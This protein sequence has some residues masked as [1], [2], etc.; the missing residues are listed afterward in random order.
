MEQSDKQLISAYLAGDDKSLAL[1][2]NRYIRLVYGYAYG[3]LHNVSD[4]EDVAQEV[5][6]KVWLNLKKFDQSKNF[7]TWLY[8]I[9]KNT[10]I[11]YLRKK[12]DLPFS[13]FTT[14][15]GDN[16]LLDNIATDTISPADYAENQLLWQRL[17]VA[18]KSLSAEQQSVINLKIETDL[19]WSAL[20]Q[21]LGQSVNTVKSRYLRAIINLRNI[22]S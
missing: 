10:I 13:A 6:V 2:V 18:S 22:L 4:A 3:Y 12:K 17:A 7:K 20:G 21:I 19:N 16:Y 1:L 8:K 9:S 5:F 11:D 15:E 14:A